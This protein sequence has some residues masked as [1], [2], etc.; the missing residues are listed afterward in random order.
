MIGSMTCKGAWVIQHSD[1][2]TSRVLI[3]KSFQ[4]YKTLCEIMLI[5]HHWPPLWVTLLYFIATSQTKAV[6]SLKGCYGDLSSPVA[7]IT[8]DATDQGALTGQTSSRPD[9]NKQRSGI[10][11]EIHFITRERAVR[12]ERHRRAAVRQVD[13]SQ[14]CVKPI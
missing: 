7:I 10:W 9:K 2:R 3:F 6:G 8:D 14:R 12:T 5:I 11:S 13:T 4:V 1:I